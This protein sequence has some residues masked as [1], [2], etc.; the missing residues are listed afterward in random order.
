MIA[1]LTADQWRQGRARFCR[2]MH[3]EQFLASLSTIGWTADMV[4]ALEAQVRQRMTAAPSIP[5]VEHM[6]DAAIT[7]RHGSTS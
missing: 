1:P 4:A 6:L 2:D 3:P 7:V 5:L